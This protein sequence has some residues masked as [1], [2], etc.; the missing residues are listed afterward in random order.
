[1]ASVEATRCAT[2]DPT[3]RTFPISGTYRDLTI[4]GH[5]DLSFDPIY[6]WSCHMNSPAYFE[7]QAD[8]PERAIGF[9]TVVFGWGF[10]KVT[11]LP[12]DY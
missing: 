12:I 5:P 1:V 3:A 11:G 4:L 2:S 6:Q 8:D 9:Y 10:T 7:I